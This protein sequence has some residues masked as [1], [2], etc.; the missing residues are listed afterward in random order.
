M[1]ELAT[2]APIAHFK[3]ILRGGNRTGKTSGIN[4][5]LDYKHLGPWL[6][7]SHVFQDIKHIPGCIN[8]EFNH[9]I[10]TVM[11]EN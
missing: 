1:V 3:D 9:L 5:S 7:P 8:V 4:S 2:S 6:Q 10:N 11:L